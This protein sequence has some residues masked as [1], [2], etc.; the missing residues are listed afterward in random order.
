MKKIVLCLLV[1]VFALALHA[2]ESH[3]GQD[4]MWMDLNGSWKFNT[5]N[6]AKFAKLKFDDSNWNDMMVPTWDAGFTGFAW[7]RKTITLSIKNKQA[8][9]LTLGQ[10]DDNCEVYFNGQMVK[11][12]DN[13]RPGND[14]S[15]TS[16]YSQWKKYRVYYIPQKLVE[17]GK[18]NTI[19]IKVWNNGG[20]GGM[21]YGNVQLTSTIFYNHLPIQMAGDWVKTDGSNEWLAGFYD[22]NVIYKNRVWKYAEVTNS[23][24]LYE[25]YLTDKGFG[26]LFMK[27]VAGENGTVNLAIGPDADHL[28]LCSR[29]ETYNTSASNNQTYIKL[30][31]AAGTAIYKGFIKNYSMRMGPEALINLQ[32]KNNGF[33]EKRVSVDRFGAFS[34]E[35]ALTEPTIVTLRAPG[36]NYGN[37][38]YLEPGKTT[39]QMVDLAEFKI[40]VTEEFYTRDHLAMFQ[41]DLAMENKL[42]M[43]IDWLGNLQTPMPDTWARFI[44]MASQYEASGKASDLQMNNIALCIADNYQKYNDTVALAKAKLWSVRTLKT[45][46]DNHLF[47]STLNTILQNL[48]EHLDGLQYLAK[49][50]DLAD[51]DKDQQSVNDYKLKIKQYV[52]EMLK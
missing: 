30:Q 44:A 48:G 36:V 12:Y 33:S 31:P 10:V 49:A 11:L 47:Y 43:Y 45:N 50:L 6:N 19:A 24:G 7:Y 38:A 3:K 23:N 28:E 39:F 26:H 42:L 16:V 14:I 41:G 35:L 20:E 34:T 29:K 17:P 21:R 27:Q 1:T 52:S 9:S 13:P 15:D 2:Q 4:Y 46:A 8:L 51:K 5:G 18:A 32:G 22:N 37:R 40:Y 25:M